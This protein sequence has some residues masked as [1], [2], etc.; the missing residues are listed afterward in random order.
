MSNIDFDPTK[1]PYTRDPNLTP[2]EHLSKLFDKL[3][4]VEQQSDK[5]DKYADNGQDR[6]Y[7]EHIKNN[8]WTKKRDSEDNA[9]YL[10]HNVPIDIDEEFKKSKGNCYNLNLNPVDCKAFIDIILYSSPREAAEQIGN[11]IK[12]KSFSFGDLRSTINDVHPELALIILKRFGFKVDKK[13]EIISVGDWL[14]HYV[15]KY[16]NNAAIEKI[17]RKNDK[18]LDFLNYLV[19]FINYN[20]QILKLNVEKIYKNQQEMKNATKTMEKYYFI[21]LNV[22]ELE[23]TLKYKKISQM[24]S[25]KSTNV[26]PY[27]FGNLTSTNFGDVMNPLYGGN[28]EQDMDDDGII[29]K[30]YTHGY[31]LMSIYFNNVKSEL[32]KY[33]KYLDPK[34]EKFI[35]RQIENLKYYEKDIYKKLALIG[36]YVQNKESSEST[37]IGDQ[38]INK[39]KNF[40]RSNNLAELKK[41]FKYSKGNYNLLEDQVINAL[42]L[43]FE[44]L[45]S[46]NHQVPI[47]LD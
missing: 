12:D 34:D 25:L 43:E 46:T 42:L 33:G 21:P 4:D 36:E 8:Y 9:V 38:D 15:S 14:E 30:P 11:L 16:F 31:N 18:L 47:P 13:N 22:N 27:A 19:R 7:D 29:I 39:L 41:K 37:T 23:N 17:I 3:V 35:K 28:K 44:K 20:P 10:K 45:K 40:N 5:M 6:V 26:N 1:Y 2:E 24:N 32:A